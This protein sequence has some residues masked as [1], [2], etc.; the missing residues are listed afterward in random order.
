ML[1]IDGSWLYSNTP[2]LAE[3]NEGSDF[4]IDFGKLP[5]ILVQELEQ[6]HPRLDLDL[7]RTYFFSS[8]ATNYDQRDEEAVEKRL[9]FFEMLREKYQ[10]EVEVFPIDFRGRRLSKEDRDEGD[11]FEPR[12]KCVDIS[13]AS[14]L[15]YNAAIPNAYDIALCVLGER[16]FKPALKNVRR[17]GNRVAI[18]SIRDSCAPEIMDESDQSGLRDFEVLWLDDLVDEIKLTYD[19]HKLVCQSPMHEGEREVW[20]TYHPK[21]G[22]KFYCDECRRKYKEKQKGSREDESRQSVQAGTPASETPDA[23]EPAREP[24]E[25]QQTGSRA[26]I[27]NGT[28]GSS[29]PPSPSVAESNAD[30]REQSGQVKKKFPDRGYGFI[31][32]ENGRDYFFHLSDLMFDLNFD[33]IFEGLEVDFMIKKESDDEEAGAATNVRAS[34]GG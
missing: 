25:E 9:N 1:F 14:S 29:T 24:Q 27:T 21:D 11:H 33:D 23:P 19:R 30:N 10:Y 28:G 18:A 7:V 26:N 16:D 12:E 2:K 4:R 32:A 17:L 13:L 31:E 22:E 5:R 20:T 3:L 34:G 6:N 15:V 8:Y